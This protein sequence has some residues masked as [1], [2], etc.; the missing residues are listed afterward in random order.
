[1]DNRDGTISIFTTVVDHAAP[2]A[3]PAGCPGQPETAT[4]R[5]AE[6]FDHHELASIGRTFSFNDPDNDGT[7]TGR[8]IDRNAELLLEAPRFAGR[9]PRCRGKR[10]TL[11]G[12]RGHDRGRR[13]LVGTRGRDV[14][15]SG[16]GKDVILGRGGNDIVCAG[17]GADR[18]QGGRGRDALYGRGGRDLLRG[19]AGRDRLW[20]RRGPDRLFGGAG[21]DRLFGGRAADRLRGKRGRDRQNGGPGRD[22]CDRVRDRGAPRLSCERRG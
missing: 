16:R 3:T 10:A 18:V 6:G 12:T 7:G 5:C 4:P 9:V 17:A 11:V 22:F 19:N 13:K 14:I 1:M 2:A 15:V 20:G 21:G 8:V